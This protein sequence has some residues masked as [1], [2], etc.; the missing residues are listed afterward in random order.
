MSLAEKKL[1]I[2]RVVFIGRTF[3]EY[4]AMFNLNE[5]HLKG[6]KVLDCA[7]GACSFTAHALQ[8]GTTATSCDI[9]YTFTAEELEKREVWI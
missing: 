7:S 6:K 5:R 2:D 4:K 3:E 1:E 9:A 8:Q